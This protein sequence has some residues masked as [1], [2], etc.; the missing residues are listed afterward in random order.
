MIL[1]CVLFGSRLVNKMSV[2]S[3]WDKINPILVIFVVLE[4]GCFRISKKTRITLCKSY[5]FS[6]WTNCVCVRVWKTGHE[7]DM[8][9]ELANE[10]RKVL[11]IVRE[12]TSKDKRLI[13]PS[14][15]PLKS[16]M[17]S[18]F[19]SSSHLGHGFVVASNPAA[20]I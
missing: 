3:N 20:I 5:C 14:H 1:V 13:G 7:D 15:I 9:I 19:T 2:W 11:G 12:I 17:A 16:H 10:V 6:Q 4:L 18:T 8:V